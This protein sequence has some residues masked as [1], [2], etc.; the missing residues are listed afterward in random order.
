MRQVNPDVIMVQEHWLTS[1]NLFKLSDISVFGSSHMDARIAAGPLVG[2]PFGGT[3]IRIKN[4]FVNLTVSVATCERFTAIKLSNWLLVNVYLPCSG[5]DQRLL[6]YSDVLC[7]VQS[8]ISAH[9]DC[10][11]I[12][13][14]DF[15]SDLK[16]AKSHAINHMINDF[17]VTNNL[18]RCDVVFPVATKYTYINESLNCSSTIDYMLTSNC[19]STIAFN[20]L[21]LDLNLSDHLPIMAI[22]ALNADLSNATCNANPSVDDVTHLRWDHAQINEYYDLTRLGLDP[23]LSELTEVI[24]NCHCTPESVIADHIDALYDRVVNVLSQCADQCVPKQ[25]KNFFKFWWSQELAELKEKA[26]A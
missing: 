15:N 20:I 9:S 11:C 13:G 26:I 19:G 4:D 14:G 10:D 12:V 23:V 17:V 3:A 6:I 7:E 21:D 1:D 24:N 25:R 2:R 8:L 16:D 22:L 5:T 18:Y